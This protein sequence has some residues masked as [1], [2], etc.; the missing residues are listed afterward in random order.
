VLFISTPEACVPADTIPEEKSD[1]VP[2]HLRLGFHIKNM[3]GILMLGT[4]QSFASYSVDDLKKAKQFYQKTLGLEVSESAEGLEMHPH[5]TSVFIYPK[6]NHQPA[7]FT[8]LNFLVDDIEA[9]VKDLRQ[10]GVSFER[11][12][13][14]IKTDKNGIHRNDGPAIAW[15]KDPAGN[16]LSVIEQE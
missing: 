4:N 2:T 3:G 10:K 11:Y 14:S 15:F 12:E 8:V 13:G 6:P 7:T 16:I 5:D 9:A 1:R